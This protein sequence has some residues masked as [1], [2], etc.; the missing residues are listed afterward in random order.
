VPCFNQEKTVAD[1]LATIADAMRTVERSYEI[2]VIDD[3]SQDGSLARLRDYMDRHPQAA[4]VLRANKSRK[5]AAQNYVDAAFIG[6]GRYFWL[7][8]GDNSESMETMV[9]ILRTLGEA[10]IVMPY[11]LAGLRND[12]RRTFVTHVYT[13]LMNLLLRHRFN[14]YSGQPVHL[15]YNVMRWHCNASGRGFQEELLGCLLD[16]GFT[17]KQVPYRRKPNAANHADTLSWPR[18]FSLFHTMFNIILRRISH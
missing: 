17:C 16:L 6:R 11:S 10:D 9:D 13:Q 15:R 2:V 8:P 5:G 1:T 4:I 3:G 14:D 12:S 7:V 18:F